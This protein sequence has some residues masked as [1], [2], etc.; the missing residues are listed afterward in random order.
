MHPDTP[1]TV[2]SYKNCTTL[3]DAHNKRPN[4]F[5]K[6]HENHKHKKHQKK[7]KKTKKPKKQK[8]KLIMPK[9][10]KK[11]FSRTPAK[12]IAHADNSG[13]CFLFFCFFG[14][15]WFFG[16]L[17]VSRVALLVS[18][19][20]FLRAG[21]LR[22]VFPLCQSRGLT[23]ACFRVVGYFTTCYNAGSTIPFV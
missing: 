14:F 1:N 3:A 7:T 10:T 18:V 6:C 4:T 2:R 15:F 9:K 17:A 12:L 19:C 13:K 22:V 23:T 11:N 21:S 8:R 5:R 20:R 16:S